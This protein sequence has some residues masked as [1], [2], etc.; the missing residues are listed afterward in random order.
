MFTHL[1]K[2]LFFFFFF[3]GGGALLWCVLNRK[4]TLASTSVFAHILYAFL[5]IL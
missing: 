1:V 4:P 5:S 3:G 2:L